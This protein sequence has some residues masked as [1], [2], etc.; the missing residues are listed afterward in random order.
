[1]DVKKSH[2]YKI[3]TWYS[4]NINISLSSKSSETSRK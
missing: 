1:M 4:T 2:A 3:V